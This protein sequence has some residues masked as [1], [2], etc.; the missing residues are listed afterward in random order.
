MIHVPD[1]LGCIVQ[2]PTTEEA[3]EA[4][5]GAI[6]EYLQ[7]MRQHGEATDPESPITTVVAEHITEGPWLGQGI[8][9]LATDLQPVSAEEL[10]VLVRRL[11]WIRADL[12]KLLGDVPPEQIASEDGPGRSIYRILEH[13]SEAHGVYLRSTVGKV[14]G[15]AEALRAVR[16]ASSEDRVAALARMWELSE[17]RI[18]AMTHTERE[19]AVKHGQVTWTAR[20]GLR[21]SLEHEWEHRQELMKRLDVP[22]G[23]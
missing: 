1:L 14:D 2:G 5:P 12:L 9:E 23:N 13:I 19:Q 17:A 22:R 20:R 18:A 16:Q 3:L 6:R 10:K 7:F 21:R 4:A 8:V 11:G 15:L